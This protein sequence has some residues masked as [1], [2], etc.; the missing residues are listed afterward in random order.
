MF[1]KLLVANR[2]EIAVRVIRACRALG[3]RSVAIYSEA[4]RD[5]LHVRWADEA[6][7]CGPA[8]AS[9]S[10]LD[11][12]G[13]VEIAKRAGV[14]AIHPGYGF[15]SENAAFAEAVRAAG[16]VFIG[17]TPEVI[18]AMGLKVAARARMIEAGV[19]VVPGCDEIRDLETA[20]KAAAEIGYP[21]LVKAS[22]GGGGR[23]M[24][25]VED[26]TGLAT[27]LERAKSEA[28][29]AFN[30]GAVYL[31]KLLAGPRH[32]EIQIMADSTGHV[33][34]LGERECSIQRRHQKLVEEAPAYGMTP[35]R[36]AAMGAA[37]VRAA[38][39]VDYVGAGTCEFL[40]DA[41]GE[42]HFLEM[43][44]RIQVEHPV[45]EAVTGIDLVETQIRV[46]A[47][48]PLP[49]TQ[50]DV[51]IEG[52]AIE[53]RIYAEDPEKGFIPSPGR[54]EAWSAPSGPGVRLDSGFEGGQ[55]IS[56][57]YDPMI[58]KLLTSGRDREQ[59]LSRMQSALDEFA[60]AGI[61]TG[62][63]FL[64]RLVE[65]EAFRRGAYDTG[66]I[67]DEMGD[68]PGALRLADRDLVFGVLAV[69]AARRLEAT[70]ADV[71]VTIP[72]AFAFSL[73]RQD[74][75]QVTVLSSENPCR[76]RIE[77]R[78]RELEVG[79]DASV[80]IHVLVAGIPTRLEIVSRKQ[81]GFDVGLRDRV[82]RVKEVSPG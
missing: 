14:D 46:A 65:N 22:A 13:I 23:G 54:I 12:A 3:I 51:R 49:F 71:A 61:R 73:P 48:E 31:E 59:A 64:R 47:G 77:E 19:P 39:A 80:L 29:E 67:E 34:H 21:I 35:E 75:V 10:Y 42:F 28:A 56:A 58:A 17:P 37:A 78:E 20:R 41:A 70:Q 76:V 4:D 53:A 18:R 6:Y 69:F 57:H 15:L 2:G 33:V 60:I 55:T 81:G 25:R 82:L 62:L 36:R 45:T 8:R 66:F 50:Q 5:A 68:G 72:P 24:R 52:H 16:I 7:A 30:D 43:N 9:E 44:T 63:P 32:I 1:E 79:R 26:E 74:A 38:Q 40:V 27:A 11:G